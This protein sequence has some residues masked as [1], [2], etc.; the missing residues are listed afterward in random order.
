MKDAMTDVANEHVEV[1]ASK[2]PS[3][4]LTFVGGREW[5]LEEDYTYV[6][7]DHRITVPAGFQFDLS[8]VPRSLWWLISPFELSIVAPLLHDFLYAY[9]GDPPPGSI[10][11]PRTYTR[12]EADE[13]FRRIMEQEGVAPWRRRLAYAAVRVFGR[14]AWQSGSGG[15]PV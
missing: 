12:R 1:A 5:R 14:G 9:G 3:P 10:E 4:V 2:L 13:L 15:D 7:G 11:P 8:S 6:D